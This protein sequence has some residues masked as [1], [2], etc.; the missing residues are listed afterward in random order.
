MRRLPGIPIL[1]RKNRK[2]IGT[3]SVYPGAR[4]IAHGECRPSGAG[5]RLWAWIEA[6]QP[7]REFTRTV[8]NKWSTTASSLFMK[9]IVGKD[10]E[11]KPRAPDKAFPPKAQ[12][13]EFVGRHQSRATT[14]IGIGCHVPRPLGASEK[15]FRK[16]L[17]N[18]F[19]K[20]R[21]AFRK[22]GVPQNSDSGQRLSAVET[23]GRETSGGSVRACSERDIRQ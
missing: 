9:R 18:R 1:V 16:C 15:P 13:A 4:S 20:L 22:S 12:M 3:C 21:N 10:N 17:Q 14:R 19:R 8:Y 6:L 11:T 23:I 2:C 7:F 5:Q